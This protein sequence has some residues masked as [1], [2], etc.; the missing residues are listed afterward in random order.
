MS[1]NWSW[2]NGN[3]SNSK[4]IGKV[5]NIGDV[6]VIVKIRKINNWKYFK[7][8]KLNEVKNWIYFFVIC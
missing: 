1:I 8:D 6:M 4:I 5:I 2:L 3:V 7:F